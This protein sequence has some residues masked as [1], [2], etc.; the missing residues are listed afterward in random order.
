MN[1]ALE[2]I[3]PQPAP[4]AAEMLVSDSFLPLASQEIHM[5]VAYLA[6]NH[7]YFEGMIDAVDCE[8]LEG[9]DSANR[10]SNANRNMLEML[11]GPLGGR[12]EV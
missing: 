10:R 8:E 3:V 4:L 9:E 1:L 11:G 2:S 12:T 6:M 5:R 7:S